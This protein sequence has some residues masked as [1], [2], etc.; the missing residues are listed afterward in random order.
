MKGVLYKTAIWVTKYQS[1]ERSRK[2]NMGF[3]KVIFF[4]RKFMTN[5]CYMYKQWDPCQSAYRTV[6]VFSE[7]QL[8][9]RPQ[10]HSWPK[11]RST[12]RATKNTYFCISVCPTQVRVFAK[13][14]R[15][16][17]KVFAKDGLPY[18][19]CRTIF[20]TSPTWWRSAA[21]TKQPH[22]IFTLYIVLVYTPYVPGFGVNM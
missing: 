12:T 3:A 11:L 9:R 21:T 13:V 6:V 16:F 7:S 8:Q 22:C 14:L 2:L 1:G 4:S 19:V 20:F 5:I 17:A 15:K 10:V 18:P